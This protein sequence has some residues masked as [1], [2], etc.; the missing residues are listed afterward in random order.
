MKDH[1][2]KTSAREICRKHG[3]RSV[4]VV[5]MDDNDIIVEGWS[6]TKQAQKVTDALVSMTMAMIG[7]QLSAAAAAANA[8]RGNNRNLRVAE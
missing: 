6:P 8:T 3:A 1:S 5:V 2:A 4:I 7:G